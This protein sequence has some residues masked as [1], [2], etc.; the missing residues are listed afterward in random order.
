MCALQVE[1]VSNALGK[2]GERERE[3]E[4]SGTARLISASVMPR[5][6]WICVTDQQTHRHSDRSKRERERERERE[7][8]RTDTP[9]TRHPTTPRPQKTHPPN[10]QMY[11]SVPLV[12]HLNLLH[13][14]WI[15]VGFLQVLCSI[16]LDF[17][18]R[19]EELCTLH[20][21]HPSRTVHFQTLA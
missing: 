18:L 13:S 19:A 5:S 8:G 17:I 15:P 21:P 14:F 12:T 3:R 16:S 10:T 20:P 1:G 2:Q 6:V 9:D 4:R 7:D 11:S